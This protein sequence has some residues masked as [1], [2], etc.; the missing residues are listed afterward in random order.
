MHDSRI[1]DHRPLSIPR[2]PNFDART[3]ARTSARSAG[4]SALTAAAVAA[5]LACLG[6]GFSTPAAMSAPPEAKSP[7]QKPS[8]QKPPEKKPPENKP[9]EKNAEKK[10]PDRF[11]LPVAMHPQETELWCWAATGQM[12]ME[13]LGKQVPQ[14]DQANRLFKRMDC[15]DHPVPKEC[16]RGGEVII[17]EYGFSAELSRKP[18]TEEEL[19][20]QIHALR[21][22]V[23]FAWT[24]SGG[25]GHIGL[26]VGYARTE[27]GTLLVEILDP[28][29]PPGKSAA[30][31]EGGQRGFMSYRKWV[32]SA[33]GK[34][35]HVLFNIVKKP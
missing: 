4:F 9:A 23:P 5:S 11:T 29:P 17:P 16:I 31:P 25:G 33:E 1:R 20:R 34:F 8:A 10:P 21:A 24:W 3:R 6:W 19:I 18:L 13:F 12:A 7:E 26:V 35:D 22:P 30:N 14:G 27:S 32:G 28:Y 2:S 15:D